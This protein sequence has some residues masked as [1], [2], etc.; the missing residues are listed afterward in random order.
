MGRVAPDRDL[1]TK[2]QRS[3]HQASIMSGDLRE[4]LAHGRKPKL[5]GWAESVIVD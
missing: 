4:H 3:R 5:Q 1:S 2:S